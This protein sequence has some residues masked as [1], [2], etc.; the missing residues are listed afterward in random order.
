MVHGTVELTLAMENKVFK[1]VYVHVC[2]EF[3]ILY[4]LIT[5]NCV[6][7]TWT[8][9]WVNGDDNA[10]KKVLKSVYMYSELYIYAHILNPSTGNMY[11]GIAC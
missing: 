2:P 8:N 3:V 10:M 4:V 7:D 9:R 6:C 1:S 5:S 11:E